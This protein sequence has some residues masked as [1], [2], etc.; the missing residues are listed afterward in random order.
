MKHDV[1]NIVVMQ[2]IQI[3][4]VEWYLRDHL[5]RQSNQGRQQF[6]KELLAS[7]MINLYL[8]YRNSNLKHMDDMITTV[9]ENLVSRQV[10]KKTENNSLEVTDR[11]S[12]LQCSKCFYIS[13]LNSN[14][15]RNCFRCSSVELYDFPKK[16]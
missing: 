14:E 10:I 13:Y 11:F 16:K 6:K 8:R 15:P 4:E 3:N 7:E 1:F 5:F 12:R 2:D 9:I